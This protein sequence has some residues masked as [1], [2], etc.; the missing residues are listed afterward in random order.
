MKT[1][2]KFRFFLIFFL[3]LLYSILISQKVNFE[4]ADLGR[5]IKNGELILQGDTLQKVLSTNLYSYTYPDF[6]FV[7]HHW[8]SGVIFYLV[9]WAGGFSGISIFFLLVSLITFGFFFSLAVKKSNFATAFLVATALMPLIADRAEIRPE[10]F[11]Y[12]FCGIFWWILDKASQVEKGRQWRWLFL[13]PMLEICWV[14]LHIYFFLGFVFLGFFL[15]EKVIKKG[16][17]ESRDF[18]LTLILCGLTSLLNPAGVKG[19]LYPLQI[20]GN[21]GYRVLENQSILFLDKIIKYPPGLYFKIGFGLLLLSWVLVFWKRKTFSFVDLILTVFISY[22]GWTAVRNFS[23][24]G[25][26]ALP[27]ISSNLG[28]FSFS[29]SLG[30]EGQDNASRFFLLSSLTM[31][32]IFILFLTNIPYFRSKSS[33]GFGLQRGEEQGAEFFLKEQLQGPIFNN[34]DNGSYLIYYLYPQERVFVDNRPEA[35]PK[36]FFEK[37]YIPMQEDEKIWKKMEEKYHFNI[38]F[39]YRHDLTPWAQTFLINRIDDPSW[40]P[41]YVDN[42]SIIFAK[43]NEKNKKV[44]ERFELPKGMFTVQK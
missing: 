7:N 12:F 39:F 38:I 3:L 29:Q 37:T 9:Y 5:H 22:L 25:F 21:Y 13:L 23:L 27:I 43:R 17:K 33:V 35:Y 20:F 24:F 4:A 1:V 26:F 15:I 10:A 30:S 8:G 28:K 44:I 11:S 34:Y 31:L 32:I 16:I 6:P 42:Y 19:L 18:F 36:D 14:N 2:D 40:S 41:I